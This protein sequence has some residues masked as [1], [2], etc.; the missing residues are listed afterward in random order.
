MFVAEGH[1]PL[2]GR[3]ALVTGSGHGIGRVIARRLAGL[4]ARTI[5]NSFHSRERGEETCELIRSAGGEAVHVWGSVT[6][7]DHMERMFGEIEARFGFLDVFVS[8][9]ANGIVAPLHMVTTEHWNRAFQTNIFGLHQGA[10]KATPL[11]RRRGGGKIFCISSPGAQRYI[12]HFGCLGP[13]KAALESLTRYLAVELAPHNIQVNAISAGAIYGELLDKYPDGGRLVPYW[14]SR[15]PGN[16][17]GREEEIA[18]FLALLLSSWADRLTG[19]VLVAD[20][21]G[22]LR[23]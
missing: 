23:V 20:Q 6:N 19:T 9:A 16:E 12:E 8:N 3:V 5:V 21:G 13:V 15:T 7:P 18:N 10:L 11:M 17:L 4:G 2:A 22:T 14:E 1:R